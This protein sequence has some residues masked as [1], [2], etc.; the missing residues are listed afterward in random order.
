MHT[1][2]N[3]LLTS[4][5]SKLASIT[6]IVVLFSYLFIDL[7]LLYHV[8][9]LFD[10]SYYIC[11]FLIST[12][13][14]LHNIIVLHLMLCPLT[15][16][17]KVKSISTD[18]MTRGSCITFD[19]LHVTDGTQKIFIL[20]IFLHYHILSQH[21]YFGV[22]QKLFHFIVMDSSVSDYVSQLLII[23]FVPE[24]QVVIFWE[25]EDVC[26]NVESVQTLFSIGFFA[27]TL[28]LIAD[29]DFKLGSMDVLKDKTS[30]SSNS[31]DIVFDFPLKQHFDFLN[32]KL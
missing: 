31:N 10:L 3:C 2:V 28:E 24:K 30:P 21:F 14:T 23:I 4:Y 1:F 15:K 16:A 29:G 26:E 7:L 8:L 9:L 17:L 18:S 13:R 32:L 22:F 6:V 25:I 20:I 27:R 11:W 5:L 19:D 12:K